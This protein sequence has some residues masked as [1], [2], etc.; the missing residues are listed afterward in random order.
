M[1]KIFPLFCQGEPKNA[2]SHLNKLKQKH[3]RWAHCEKE[4]SAG[5][6]LCNQVRHLF[7]VERLNLRQI[8]K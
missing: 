6:I 7:E 8:A 2:R 3:P 5:P 1:D 4:G